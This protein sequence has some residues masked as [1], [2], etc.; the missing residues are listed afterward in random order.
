MGEAFL[1][2]SQGPFRTRIFRQE[3]NL[4]FL[5]GFDTR[6]APKTFESIYSEIEFSPLSR[7]T[8]A[9][10]FQMKDRDEVSFRSIAEQVGAAERQH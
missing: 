7:L 5:N 1:D 9:Q 10:T 6:M 2:L 3:L 8:L 4:P